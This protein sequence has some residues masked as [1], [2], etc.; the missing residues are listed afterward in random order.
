MKNTPGNN[1]QV[2]L[3]V[4]ERFDI[5]WALFELC[6]DNIVIVRLDDDVILDLER[7]E[8]FMQKLREV[9]NGSRVRMLFIPGIHTVNDEASRNYFARKEQAEIIACC[10]VVISSMAQRLLGNFFLKINK[11]AVSTRL[12]NDC[13]EGWDWLL[14]NAAKKR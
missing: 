10:A 4:L 3:P 11:P 9:S 1:F 13:R 12:V 7:S 2:P 5:S 8:I 14:G 6:E